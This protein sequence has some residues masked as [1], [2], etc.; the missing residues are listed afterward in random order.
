MPKTRRYC[1][2]QSCDNFIGT[3]SDDI[4]MFRLDSFGQQRSTMD[5][6]IQKQLKNV[7][8]S[9]RLPI[10]KEQKKLWVN[11]INNNNDE[12]HKCNGIGFVCNLHFSPNHLYMYKG[13]LKLRQTAVP[14]NFVDNSEIN[15]QHAENID[16]V[17]DNNYNCHGCSALRIELAELKPTLLQT[18]ITSD[19]V[20]AENQ[21]LKEKVRA[22]EKALSGSKLHA[23]KLEHELERIISRKIEVILCHDYLF[24][25]LTNLL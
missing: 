22:L 25:F 7:N 18:Q 19:Q 4:H 16:P 6:N 15:L 24:C 13:D 9:Y 12:H 2:I 11:A 5:K 10:E 21:I 14:V 1:V 23:K 17:K 3:T 8:Y 20:V